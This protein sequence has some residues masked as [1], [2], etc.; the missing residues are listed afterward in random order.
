MT[1]RYVIV[2][3]FAEKLFE[4]AQ[5]AV[6][7]DGDTLSDETMQKIA[8]EFNLWRTVF[9][10]TENNNS[11]LSIRTFNHKR[12]FDFGGHATIAAIY[13]L[14]Q[15]NII[16]LTE[17]DNNFVLTEACGDINCTVS[18][19]N[20]EVVFNKFVSQTKLVIDRF[21]PTLDELASILTVKPE[22]LK[23]ESFHP[24]LVAS[25][26]PYL[27]IPVDN[28]ATLESV[29]FD[30]KAWAASTAPATFA[31]AIFLFTTSTQNEKLYFHCRLLGP[32][33]SIH[34]DPPIGA[35]IPA[36]SGYLNQFI[37]Q[38]L[39]L[40]FTAQ[41]GSEARRVSVIEAGLLSVVEDNVEVSI[42]GNAILVAEGKLYL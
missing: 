1:C 19:K 3:V 24:M 2:D 6:V 21:T 11:S 17:G 5:I 10:K 39:P 14:A 32:N 18:I 4:G 20:N 30:Y 15:Q 13:T 9:L 7:L 37:K 29:H 23:V 25:H 42:G 26:V 35:A 31:N 28:V 8:T 16:T 33:F 41:R 22:Q 40:K 27:F 36:F 34:D 38:D 12:E